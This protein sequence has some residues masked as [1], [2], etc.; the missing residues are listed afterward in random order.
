[1]ADEIIDLVRR[2]EPILIFHP[3][4]RFFPSDA[5]RYIEHCALWKAEPPFDQ[6]DSWGGK[7]QPFDRKPLI[8][9]EKIAAS[10]VFGEVRQGTIYLGTQQGSAFPFLGNGEERFLELA[11]WKDSPGVRKASANRYANRDKVENLYNTNTVPDL[12]NSRFWYHA[13]LFNAERLRRLLVPQEPSS[14][15]PDL[16]NVFKDLAPRNPALLCYYFFFPA[17]DES[18]PAP[19]DQKETG[20]EFAG[21]AGEWACMALLLERG[22]ESEPYSPVFI[23][24]TGR[25]NVGSGQGLDGERRFGMTVSKWRE[26]VGDPG[27]HV[28]PL[29]QTLGDHPQLFVSVGVHSLHLTPGTQVVEP[30]LPETTPIGCGNFDSPDV[31]KEYFDSLPAPEEEGSPAAAWAKIVGGSFFGGLPGL[32]AGAVL[33]ALEGLPLGAGFSGKATGSGPPLN[34]ATDIGPEPATLFGLIVHPK[35]FALSQ[36][37]FPGGN[38]VA[39]AADQNVEVAGRRYNFIVDRPAQIWWPSD[40]GKSGYGGRWGPL[41][42]NDPLRR[43]SGMRFPEFWKMFFVALAKMQ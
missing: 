30:Y 3:S 7:G 40:D 15:L 19:C 16:G 43:R 37:D 2:F 5:K 1:M 21:F 14:A 4:E 29:P 34:P 42:A 26:R 24:Y 41:V 6:K 10:N 31:L 9:H 39:W 11:G 8:P 27:L 13:E 35:G 28:P 20:K 18:L 22:S 33:T 38:F 17:H 25:L 12:H 36:A 32:I 23:G